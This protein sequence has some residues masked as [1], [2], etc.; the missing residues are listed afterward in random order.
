MTYGQAGQ[1]RADLA[2]GL[3]HLGMRSRDALGLYGVN[4]SE[5]VLLD[6]AAYVPRPHPRGR[7]AVLPHYSRHHPRLDPIAPIAPTAPI[8]PIAP[9]APT[10]SIGPT[11]PT[12]PIAP[13]APIAPLCLSRA[14]L[15]VVTVPLYDTLGPDAVRYIASHAELSVIACSVRV[16]P[17]LLQ[18]V[19]E[20]PTARAIVVWG[21]AP[22]GAVPRDADGGRVRVLTFEEL[23][24]VGR[25]NPTGGH[26]PD[27]TD[28]H[29]ICY[30]SGTTG[31]P[32]GVILTHGNLI[33]N[34]AG[35]MGYVPMTPDDTFISYLPLAHIYERVFMLQLVR[36]RPVV[37]PTRSM[38]HEGSSSGLKDHF[39]R[40][41]ST[42][43]P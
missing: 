31:V 22:S 30:T 4:A 32:K 13:I 20:C 7:H 23:Q 1:L 5:W 11:A 16:L 9:I 29:T 36:A 14:S 26:P 33:A 17:T 19:H 37:T 43:P 28:V 27:P 40:A 42:T 21:R 35:M 34:C 18:T 15:S 24:Q 12:A 38:S 39:I 25:L 10:A 3:A 41:T 2:S 6:A 8:A